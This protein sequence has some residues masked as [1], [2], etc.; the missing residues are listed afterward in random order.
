M[1]PAPE[2][3]LHALLAVGQEPAEQDCGAVLYSKGQ[4]ILGLGLLFNEA[5]SC[6]NHLTLAGLLLPAGH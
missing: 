3:F 1:A 2:E 4:V 6:G 5:R